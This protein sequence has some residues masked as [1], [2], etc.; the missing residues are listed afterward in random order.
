LNAQSHNMT[1]YHNRTYVSTAAMLLLDA[2][3]S[4]YAPLRYAC[5]PFLRSPEGGG[6]LGGF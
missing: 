1:V 6:F 3:R 2:V 4:G 5:L